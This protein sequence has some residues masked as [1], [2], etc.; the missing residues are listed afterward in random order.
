MSLLKNLSLAASLFVT[1]YALAVPDVVERSQQPSIESDRFVFHGGIS[2]VFDEETIPA[3]ALEYRWAASK[4]GL[5]PWLGGGWA[6]DGA[7]FAGA[8]MLH[9]WRPAKRWELVAGF[10]P[11]Y[12]DRHEGLDLGSQMEFYSFAEANWGI[13]QGKRLLLRVAHIS[14]ASTSEINPG[15]E[16]LTLGFSVDLR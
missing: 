14:N 3:F 6:T 1:A 8:G 2:G 16:L 10:G 12:Y 4:A 13:L 5:Q 9:T 11:G 15:T 7:I